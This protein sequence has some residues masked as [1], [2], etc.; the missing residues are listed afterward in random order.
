[1]FLKMKNVLIIIFCL[2]FC[3][4]LMAQ[5]KQ[6]TVEVVTIKTPGINCEDCQTY[7]EGKM[8]RYDGI[9]EITADPYSKKTR[10]EYYTSRQDTAT[11]ISLIASLGFVANDELPAPQLLPR[12]PQCCREEAKKTYLAKVAEL[13][14][15]AKKKNETP[16]PAPP[17]PKVDSTKAKP[18]IPVKPIVVPAPKAPATKPNTKKPATP[19]KPA[20][21]PKAT[22]PKSTKAK[23]IA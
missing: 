1:M 19:A 16:P 11:L 10:I 9:I 6:K 23:T 14:E 3:N 5:S 2:S 7:V 20:T 4:A 22:T 21:T 17:K 18:V 8:K 13:D 12:V 15:R